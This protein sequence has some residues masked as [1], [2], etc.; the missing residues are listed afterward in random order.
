MIVIDFPYERFNFN[1]RSLDFVNF[2]FN[3]V[4]FRFNPYIDCFLR[5]ILAIVF[6]YKDSCEINDFPR[7]SIFF[8]FCF[9]LFAIPLAV[10]DND[11]DV[12]DEEASRRS[13]SLLLELLSSKSNLSISAR[14]IPSTVKV[15]STSTT[16]ESV[17][18]LFV[19]DITAIII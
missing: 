16:T 9:S 1:K 12:D 8:R 6:R 11:I 19:A 18:T 5:S 3:A 15:S 7:R 14:S 4:N 10:D 13:I 2:V 17:T